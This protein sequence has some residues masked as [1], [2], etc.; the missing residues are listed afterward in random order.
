[1]LTTS[2]YAEALDL[3]RAVRADARFEP[4]P[5]QA[6]VIELEAALM[7]ELGRGWHG[8]RL[9]EPLASIDRGVVG[10]R[11]SRAL[12]AL[13]GR[14]LSVRGMDAAS[15]AGMRDLLSGV[16]QR[17][18]YA[19]LA[20]PLLPAGEALA[21]CTSALELADGLGLKA[22][23]PGLLASRAEALCRMDQREEAAR[24]A[25]RGVRLLETTT[26]LVYRG[27][28]WLLLHGTLAALGD[29]AAAREVLLQ[30]SE[31]LHRTARR[32]VP[33]P[34]RDSFLGRNAVNRE[35]L[36]LAIRADIAPA[37]GPA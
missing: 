29:A 17:C 21:L 23:L 22:H 15:A 7:F 10:Y 34:F 4:M 33:A 32:D 31:W 35:L 3:V 25:R 1:L 20:A 8:E 19:A 11:G 14:M 16:P 6:R 27:G 18:R 2:R 30:A 5:S 28:I 12:V 36:V 13:Q 9:L 24:C 37:S 26:P